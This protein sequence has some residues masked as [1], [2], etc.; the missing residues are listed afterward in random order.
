MTAANTGVV[1]PAEARYTA[2]AGGYPTLRWLSAQSPEPEEAPVYS[3]S[4]SGTP[5][6]GECLRATASGEDGSAAANPSY[7]WQYSADGQSFEN[8]SG[9]NA[10]AYTVPEDGSFLDGW[11]RVTVQGV[12]SSSAVSAAVGPVEM[13]D[14]QKVQD[15]KEQLALAAGPAIREAV[16]LSLP[17]SGANGT[18]VSWVSSD[19][20]VVS[21]AGVVTL[22]ASGI[23]NVTLT[24]TIT[25]GEASAQKSFSF[26]VYSAAAV[27]ITAI[28]SRPAGAGGQLVPPEAG[29][30]R[31]HKCN[32]DG[33]AGACR[34]GLR[35]CVGVS[36]RE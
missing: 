15:A 20:S 23:V 9:A 1:I 26:A 5:K 24:A 2:V 10:A 30:W 34:P 22:P 17:L 28:F 8:I 19:P 4:V 3:V 33:S 7:Q 25:L 14:S 13:S 31:G 6:A 16:S 32:R 36:L 12:N 35:R 11:L 29:L 21:P 18:A 27:G